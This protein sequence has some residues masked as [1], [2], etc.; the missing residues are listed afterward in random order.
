MNI[1]SFQQVVLDADLCVVGGGLAGICA[2]VAAARHGAKTVLVQDRPMLGGNASSE[3][4]MWICGA[5]GIN[6]KETGILEEIQLEN[7]RYNP[8][9][10][11]NIW[12]H[13][14]INFV[15]RQENLTL[16][17]NCTCDSVEMD[18]NSIKS[19]HAW[20]MSSQKEYTI[21]A[22]LFADCSGDSV[23]R[24]SGAE[25]RVGREARSEFDESH[26]PEVA[27]LKTMGNSILIQTKYTDQHKPFEPLPF[28]HKFE[29]KGFHRPIAPPR[30]NFWWIETGGEQDTI[31]DAEEIRDELSKIIFGVWDLN[32]NSSKCVAKNFEIEW[33]GILPGKRENIRYVGDHILTQN[34][35]EKQGKFDDMVGY[36]GWSMDDHHPAAFYHKGAPTIFHPA[37]CPYGIPYRSLYSKNIENLFFAGRNISATHMAMSS[38]RV[39]GTC[40]ILGQAVGTAAAIAIQNDLSPRGVYEQKITELQNTLMDDDCW[41]PWHTRPISD[42]TKN[43]TLS[44]EVTCTNDVEVLR[45]GIDRGLSKKLK[46]EISL[47]ELQKAVPGSEIEPYRFVTDFGKAIEYRFEQPEMVRE[48]RLVFDSNVRDMAIKRMECHIPKGG[49]DME[50]PDTLIKEFSIQIQTM[51]G[52]EWHEVTYVE[53][54]FQRLVRI[55]VGKKAVAVRLIPEA[56]WGAENAYLY[57]FD[58]N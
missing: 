45:N 18:G 52:G 2:A 46:Q 53:D 54:N 8:S 24:V 50:L 36:G 58:V 31:A 42:L 19:V 37:P 20:Q 7:M 38:T 39:M 21:N 27:D 35:V 13:I 3:V 10:Q 22:K 29:E 30:D 25:F 56:S 14:L 23:L 16:L 40:A 47:E 11:Y 43:A 1:N 49:W 5:V 9:R 32:K 34:D 28:A 26:A 48:V 12:D 4:R 57:A 44:A 17:L 51:E 6:V 55:P 33:V 15:Q 41:L